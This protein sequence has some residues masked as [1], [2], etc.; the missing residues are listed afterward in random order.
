MSETLNELVQKNGKS[1]RK[2]NFAFFTKIGILFREFGSG[3]FKDSMEWRIFLDFL[4]QQEMNERRILGGRP[5][6]RTMAE[7][8]L[9]TFFCV[10][11]KSENEDIFFSARFWRVE[12]FG[13][14]VLEEL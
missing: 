6:L 3:K 14:V 8:E 2:G 11:K 10:E 1:V 5:R 13:V 9:N 12:S 7:E 4:D